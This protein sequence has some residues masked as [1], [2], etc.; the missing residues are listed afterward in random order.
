[1]GVWERF[2]RTGR[3]GARLGKATKGGH[4]ELSVSADSGEI[5]QMLKRVGRFWWRELRC[6]KCSG[7]ACLRRE[8]PILCV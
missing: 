3:F 2:W 5:E 4:I 6:G 8:N 1:M 7:E